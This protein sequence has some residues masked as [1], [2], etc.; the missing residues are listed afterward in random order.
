MTETLTQRVDA[1][2]DADTAR[3]VE[4]FKVIHRE[5]ELAFDEVHTART[6][7]QGLGNLGFQVTS[8]IAGT[9]VAGCWRTGPARP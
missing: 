1:L 2:V 9:G 8:G 7:A 5:P 3:L 6:V 4:M